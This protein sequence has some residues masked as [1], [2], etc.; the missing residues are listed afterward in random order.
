MEDKKK[1]PKKKDEEL[2]YPFVSNG[3]KSEAREE[4]FFYSICLCNCPTISW[5]SFIVIISLVELVIFIIS[6]SIYG[7][8]NEEFLAP[9]PH[10]LEILGW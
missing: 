2:Y 4:N 6:C 8:T 7:I 5:A 1:Q 10:A 9:N 3:N